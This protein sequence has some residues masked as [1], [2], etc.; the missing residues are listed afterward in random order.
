[1]TTYVEH[2]NIFSDYYG[3]YMRTK[4]M[5][6]KKHPKNEKTQPTMDWDV[7]MSLL[8]V[9]STVQNYVRQ[10]T[11]CFMTYLIHEQHHT[12]VKVRKG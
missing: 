1:M 5:I 10:S 9:R 12:I 7:Y 8:N 3:R 2:I 6:Q 11:S 4:C